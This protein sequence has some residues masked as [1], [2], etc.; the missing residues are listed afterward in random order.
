MTIYEFAKN[1]W[2]NAVDYIEVYTIEDATEGIAN[3][4]ACEW[5]IPE[6]ITAE[7]LCDAMN[8]VIAEVTEC[9]EADDTSDWTVGDW[10]AFAEKEAE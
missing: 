5:E 7:E 4:V 9:E 10:I 3:A 1:L 8:R 6:D 2:E